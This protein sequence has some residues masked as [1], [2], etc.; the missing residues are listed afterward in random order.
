MTDRAKVVLVDKN[1]QVLAEMDKVKAHQQGLLHRAFS[2]FIFNSEGKLLLQ[3]R[4]QS[5]YHGGGL[6][7][8]TCCSHPQLGEN[9]MDSAKERLLMEMGLK[10][11]LIFSHTFIYKVNVENDLIEHELDH[12]FIG[13]QDTHPLINKAEVQAYKWLSIEDIMEDLYQHPDKYTYWFKLAFPQVVRDLRK[14]G[15]L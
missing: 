10:C 9:V 4:A 14:Q 7:T 8:N 2:I 5:K 6:W 13:F 3:Q 11:D 1:D 15:K 12:V